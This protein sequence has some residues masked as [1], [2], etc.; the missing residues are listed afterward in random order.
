MGKL[1]PV[2]IFFPL[3]HF[4]NY[5]SVIVLIYLHRIVIEKAPLVREDLDVGIEGL[6]EVANAVLND[7]RKIYCRRGSVLFDDI[8]N[9]V[10]VIA[11]AYDKR[12]FRRNIKVCSI[13][14][15]AAEE[16]EFL[17]TVLFLF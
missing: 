8:K 9:V 1:L 2:D 10:L 12:A 14:L 17:E 16:P 3:V 15:L 13:N 7:G 6:D 11:L 4:L 5:F